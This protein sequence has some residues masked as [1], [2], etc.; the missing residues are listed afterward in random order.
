MEAIY[1]S[2][3]GITSAVGQ[4]KHAFT[5]ALLEGS[6]AFSIMER[7]GRQSSLS[8]PQ[9]QG[10]QEETPAF[11]G[12]EI[13]D[14][15]LPETISKAILRTASFSAQVVLATIN[16]AWNDAQLDKV[17]PE[18]IGLIIGG[19]NFQQREL[20]QTY[21]SYQD[22]LSFLR[23]TY[24]MSF[25]DTDVCG[26]CTE[27][28]N[29]RGFAY[30]LGAA[31][32]SGQFAVIQAIQSVLSGEV[33]ACIAVGALMDI[34]YWECHALRSL[35]AMGSYKFANR[36][37]L[38]CRPFDKAHDGFIYGENCGA[39]VVERAEM[40]RK[41]DPYGRVAGWGLAMDANRNTNPSFEGEIKVIHQA[42]CRAGISAKDID[43]VNPHG[44]GS[45]IGDEIELQALKSFSLNHA[46]INTT[47]SI[48]GHGLTAAGNI[49]LIATLLQMQMSRLHPSRNLDD[50]IE[51]DFNWVKQNSVSHQIRCALKLSFGFGGVNTAICISPA[52]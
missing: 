41:S 43:Y 33:D 16:E 27:V 18:R 1:F 26:L 36:P 4:G 2:G 17:N 31:S 14:F 21:N 13:K 46:Y 12:A 11:L 34:S 19:S 20:V 8:L 30:T 23:P 7:P 48:T 28:F 24:G 49:E 37:D 9:S 44:T 25:M 3:L 39:I 15:L 29:I 35:G 5:Q 50:P 40:A 32:A 10:G 52:T 42:M 22:R 45:V 51:Q 6:H 38:A 47:K